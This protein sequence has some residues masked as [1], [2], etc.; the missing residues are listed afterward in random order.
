MARIEITPPSASLNIGEQEDFSAAGYDQGNNEVTITP[1]WTAT[2]GT[3]TPT[4]AYTAGSI[5]GI[6]YV[7]AEDG[8]VATQIWIGVFQSNLP[9][10]AVG[11]GVYESE[12]AT[13]NTETG[14]RYTLQRTTGLKPPVDWQDVPGH[15]DITVDE[16]QHTYTPPEG[17]TT[18]FYRL[19]IRE[20]P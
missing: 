5:P 13:W 8:G 7:K 1:T 14:F 6:F 2:G 10:I 4:G 17:A 20:E 12:W 16:T 9:L 15:T 19:V 18:A 11:P 3:I